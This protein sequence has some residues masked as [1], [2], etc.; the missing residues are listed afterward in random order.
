MN[1]E[2]AVGETPEELEKIVQTMIKEGYVPQGGVAGM[3]SG[4][5]MQAM[6]RRTRK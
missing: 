1:Y 5:S 2:I 3:A 4:H 6:I